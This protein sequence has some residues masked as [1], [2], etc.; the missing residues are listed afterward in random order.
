MRSRAK[1]P[2]KEIE[3]ALVFAE[4]N[5]WA[6]VRLSGHAWGKILCPW[7]DKTCRCGTFCQKS[8]WSTPRVP[9]D[10]ARQ[11]RRAVLGCIYKTGAVS[12]ESGEPKGAGEV[13][14]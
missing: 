9:E 12:D 14:E 4:A 7:N 10:V 8:V 3:A 6:V 13:D 5:G 11:I 1:H 2:S